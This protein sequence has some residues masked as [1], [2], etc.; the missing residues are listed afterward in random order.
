M[1][2][3]ADEALV[4]GPADPTPG[5]ILLEAAPPILL[6]GMS[7]VLPVRVIPLTE[8]TPPFVRF[9]MTTTEPVRLEDPNKPDSPKKLAI[10]LHEFQFG[11]VSQG[12]MGLT[13]RVPTD[14]PST[15]IDVV[16]SADFV[17]QPLASGVGSKAWIAPTT[18]FIEDA[19]T[20]APV[21]DAKGTKAGGSIIIGSVQRHP[22]Y[23]G[24][25][26]VMLDGL[27]KDFAAAPAIVAA[28]QSTFTVNLTIPESATLGEV[29]NVTVR[30]QVANGSTISKPVT[31]KILV[32]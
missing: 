1:L 6:R 3:L 28:G 25:F 4:A 14:I 21:P 2:T 27:P 19:I 7:A 31:V 12:V 32:E 22:S 24:E 15:A 17:T 18:L 26:M 16:I 23:D 11:P 10:A 13:I 9:E 8:Q 20:V 29:P 30:G 5:T